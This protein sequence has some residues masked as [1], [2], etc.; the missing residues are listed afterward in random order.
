MGINLRVERIKPEKGYTVIHNHILNDKKLTFKAK[1]ILALLLSLPPNPRNLSI[2]KIARWNKDGVSAVRSGIDELKVAGYLDVEQ[3]N[4]DL[5]QYDG[6]LWFLRDTASGADA[7]QKNRK[8]PDAEN[9]HPEEP[10]SE[11]RG[12]IN[13]Y[14]TKTSKSKKTTTT[15]LR[16]NAGDVES[17][18]F[19]AT[20]LAETQLQVRKALEQVDPE[21]R[22][23]MLDDF[24]AAV[25]AGS[26]RTSQLAWLHGVIKRYRNGQYNFK[27]LPPKPASASNPP[28]PAESVAPVPSVCPSS[29][30]P[31][32]PS[33][34]GL[35]ALSKLKKNRCRPD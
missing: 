22:Q 5:G 16:G 4:N 28:L 32:E 30:T 31:T 10:S 2:E 11:K 27:P 14:K 3:I 24:C 9:P 35:H 1:G 13:T 33:S 34:V 19:T 21:D 15:P 29:V 12:P 20:M 25:K 7:C 26:I 17:L 23:R 6:V 18:K 8:I